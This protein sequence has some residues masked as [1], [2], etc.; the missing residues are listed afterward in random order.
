MKSKY[1][2]LSE[3]RKADY[4]AYNSAFRK[5]TLPEICKQFGWYYKSDKNK[6]NTLYLGIYITKRYC[7]I[8]AIKYETEKKWKEDSI[9]IYNLALINDWVDYCVKKIISNQKSGRKPNGYWDKEHCMEDSIRFHSTKEWNKNS[10]GSYNSAKKN[11]WYEEC[12][13]NMVIQFKHKWTKEK[14]LKE[15]KKYR[16]TTEWVKHSKP[17]YQAAH[18]NGWLGECRTHMII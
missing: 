11:G 14:C 10:S 4:S 6:N 7:Y 2:S 5:G 8:D 18:R 1:N 12:K 9:S 3:W 16:T 15:A 13:S 17:S